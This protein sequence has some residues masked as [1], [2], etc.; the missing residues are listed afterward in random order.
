MDFG[1]LIDISEVDFSL[2]QDHPVTS[3]LLTG[4][5]RVPHPHIYVGCPVWVNAKWEGNVYP[6][7]TTSK[8]YLKYYAQQFPTI[9]LNSTHYSVPAEMTIYKWTQ[10]VPQGFT[11]C[12][13]VPQ[14]ISHHLKLHH[15]ES[16]TANFVKA[17]EGFREHLGTA[18]LQLS[19][20]FGP[21][22]APTL[23]RYLSEFPKEIPLAVEFRHR[24]WFSGDPRA[25][26][27]FEEM[28]KLGIGTVITDVAGRR[29]VLHQCLTTPVLTL[30][31]VGNGLHPTDYSRTD[32][33]VQRI[34]QW[35]DHGLETA[36]LF[37]HEPDNTD[38]PELARY[39]M[40]E[41]N[42][43]CGL[44]LEVPAPRVEGIQGSLF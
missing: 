19:P 2:P 26:A 31:F 5:S 3:S 29:D 43:Q 15:A 14:E 32:E 18:F 30:R 22:D 21:Q 12:P 42:R 41:L 25:A 6:L 27:T 36:Y 40:K 24:D 16:A 13:K 7:G 1:K 38:S 35:L 39:W 4:R 23:I 33:W 44:E 17:I 11:F 10:S 8:D 34:G 9:E 37:I 28:R 20:W